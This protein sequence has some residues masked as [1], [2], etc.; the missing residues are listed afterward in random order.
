[1]MRERKI[2]IR[3]FFIYQ[4]GKILKTSNMQGFTKVLGKKHCHILLVADMTTIFNKN[5]LWPFSS[6]S[7]YLFYINKC[8][9]ILTLLFKDI[10]WSFL[11][12][13]ER[14]DVFLLL[15]IQ[16][17]NLCH[18]KSWNTRLWLEQGRFALF[19]ME[20]GLQYTDKWEKQ[21]VRS[22]HTEFSLLLK[23]NYI[24]KNRF[25]QILNMC[26]ETALKI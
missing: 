7:R 11:Y 20:G 18:V 4:N 26:I 25:A 6:T 1:M 17:T 22:E 9:S 15:N 2:F 16:V 19:D 24:L 14:L 23:E 13:T 21:V 8:S 12:N 3:N 5:I 10:H